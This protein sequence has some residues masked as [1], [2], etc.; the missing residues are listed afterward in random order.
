MEK[1]HHTQEK[2]GQMSLKEYLDAVVKGSLPAFERPPPSDGSV[3]D[4]IFER[5]ETN[6]PY[7]TINS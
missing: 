7:N 4:Y 3:Y 5:L 2:Y 6:S 1:I